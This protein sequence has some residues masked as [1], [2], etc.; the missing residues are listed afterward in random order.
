[1]MESTKTDYYDGSAEPI[2][3]TS[4]ATRK[5]EKRRILTKT[6]QRLVVVLVSLP[7]RGKSF[8]S[9]KLHAYLVLGVEML[10]RSSMSEDT[11]EARIAM[12]YQSPK[13]ILTIHKSKSVEKLAHAMPIFL[14][15]TTKKRQ[16]YVKKLP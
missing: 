5:L 14:I 13:K 10:A 12:Q 11:E 7:G 9:R 4:A 3:M 1:M 8:I 15:Q 16:S 6:S 2:S